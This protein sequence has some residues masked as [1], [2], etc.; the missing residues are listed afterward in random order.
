MNF[1]QVIE[2]ERPVQAQ[3][4]HYGG[5][6]GAFR[7]RQR[8]NLKTDD[9]PQRIGDV[10]AWRGEKLAILDHE[11][12]KSIDRPALSPSTAKAMEGC[13]A[14]WAADRI[15]PHADD[16]FGPAAIGTAVHELLEELYKLAR[17]K[18]TH[19]AAIVMLLEMADKKWPDVGELK[20]AERQFI[21][22]RRAEWIAEVTEAYSG[23]WT[24]ETPSDVR[25]NQTEMKLADVE[26]SGVPMLGFID[27]V[28]TVAKGLVIVDYKSGKF[29]DGKFNGDAHGDQL[30]IYKAGLEAKTGKKVAGAMLYYTKSGKRRVVDV[31][32]SRM[33]RTLNTFRR[34][35][36]KLKDQV[37]EGEFT[38]ASSP[39]CGWCPLV[40][41]CPLALRLGLK[42]RIPS[43]TAEELG[44]L[45]EPQAETGPRPP[46]S[47][48]Q[49][50]EGAKAPSQEESPMQFAEGKPYDEIVNGKLNAN[51]YAAMA[52][53]GIASLAHEMVHKGGVRV[54][55]VSMDSVGGMLSHMVLAIQEE[56]T[57]RRDWQDGANTRARGAIRAFIETEPFP[58]FASVAA[59]Q[60]WVERGIK[61]GISLSRLMLRAYEEELPQDGWAA[62]FMPVEDRTLKAA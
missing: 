45:T 61:R 55:Q 48:H 8:V 62:D 56:M 35:W 38:T 26:V 27:R 42:P 31:S 30:R 23:I 47:A 36:R 50:I 59:R 14:R 24:I 37:A 43:S 33:A 16:P 49:I 46:A 9:G 57:G 10:V 20:E 39:L 58:F 25:V 19:R 17:T 29:Q 54:S 2:R 21:A 22:S 3:D 60:V 11:V 12:L 28:D 7:H 34:S 4:H 44:I 32:D 41:A 6:L 15:L 1:K 5:L 51:A 18:R 40:Q 52:V 53:S 13:S